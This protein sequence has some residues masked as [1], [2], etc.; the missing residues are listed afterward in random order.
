AERHLVEIAKA[1]SNDSDVL[2]MDEPT[3]AITETEV[4]H[5]FS[6]ISDQP[7]Q[8]KAIIYITHKMNQVYEIADEVA[9]FSDGAY[10]G[11]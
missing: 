4:A 11:Q 10:I 9:V 8:G 5:Q 1:V 7:A 2:I 3:S 6:I